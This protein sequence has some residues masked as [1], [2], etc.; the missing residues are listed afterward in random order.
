[1]QARR[2]FDSANLQG[3]RAAG[4]RAGGGRLR[5]RKGD[6][7]VREA[8][9]S[10]PPV[11]PPAPFYSLESVF[12]CERDVNDIFNTKARLKAMLRQIS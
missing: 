3:T 8:G 12:L 9:G 5:Y 2:C 11:P 6:S 10:N 7:R 1:M 4:K